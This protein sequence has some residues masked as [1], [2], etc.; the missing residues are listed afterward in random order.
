MG[1]KFKRRSRVSDGARVVGL[2]TLGER[3]MAEK[4]RKQ[5]ASKQKQNDQECCELYAE[6]CYSC[7]T[8]EARSTE[9]EPVAG[10]GR[11]K[12]ER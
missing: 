8:S 6:Y 9:Q 11:G 10:E 3:I 12:S 5:K 4:E 1:Y 7:N 2:L